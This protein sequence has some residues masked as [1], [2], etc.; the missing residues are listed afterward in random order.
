MMM[1][2]AAM[3][4]STRIGDGII[5]D[6]S[7]RLAATGC[8]AGYEFSEASAARYGRSRPTEESTLNADGHADT[9]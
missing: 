1:G 8:P 2:P 6:T 4:F 7:C 5:T 9:G 3:A